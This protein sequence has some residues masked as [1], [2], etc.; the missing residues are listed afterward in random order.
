MNGLT[1]IT[2]LFRLKPTIMFNVNVRGVRHAYYFPHGPDS[3]AV[4]S[5]SAFFSQ[6]ITT[7]EC[8]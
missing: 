2:Y 6:H 1:D 7:N 4:G 8:R 5:C 3:Y